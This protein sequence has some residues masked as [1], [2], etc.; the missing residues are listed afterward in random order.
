MQARSRWF[1]SAVLL[2]GLTAGLF[3]QT[4]TPSSSTATARKKKPAST[5]AAT[6]QQ[7]VDQLQQL[8]QA[9]QRQ[10]ALQNQKVD[11]LTSQ[12][13]KL[14][15]ATQQANTAA[16]KAQSNVDQ[17][18]S[19][20]T[21]AQQSAA[22][23]QKVA[24]QASANATDLKTAVTAVANKTQ[25][26]DKQLS[27]L[28]ALVGRFRFSG[29]VRVR[30]EDYFQ[31]G[32]P[33]RNRARIRVRFGVDGQLNED[34]IGGFALATGSMGDPSSTN[35]TLTNVFD[36]KTIALDRGYVTYNPVAHSWL[37]LTGGKFAYP[38]QRTS[39]TFD[40][41]L[42]PEGFNEKFSFDFSGPVQNFTVQGIE[43]R[44]NESAAGQDSYALVRK[45][46]AGL[47]SGLGQP[48][49]RSSA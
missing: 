44:Y 34:F 31:Q 13:Q 40:P 32:V 18:A 16:Q 35:E 11:Q 47:N 37:S 26:Q 23:A 29:D 6:T 33:D 38:W 5:S 42:N 22:A 14:L 25:D 48:P 7:Q 9:Q 19:A 21:Q 28:E 39:A 43:L 10:L 41:D 46:P 49:P 27:A 36:R 12:L 4:S 24:D 20:A 30:G 1:T 3:A 17:A 45:H 15:D 2:L 8:V